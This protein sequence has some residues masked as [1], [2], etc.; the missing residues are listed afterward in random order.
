[1]FRWEHMG[2]FSIFSII[3]TSVS[4]LTISNS[5][6]VYIRTIK[7]DKVFSITIITAII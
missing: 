2:T 6:G 5:L 4:P 7:Q 1:M 3:N